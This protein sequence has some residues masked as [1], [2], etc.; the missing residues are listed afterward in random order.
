M[1]LY[2]ELNNADE[3]GFGL[4]YLRECQPVEQLIGVR[5]LDARIGGIRDTVLALGAADDPRATA[6]EAIRRTHRQ[7][8]SQSW[9]RA[10]AFGVL[11]AR[12][13]GN[14]WADDLQTEEGC[15]HGR[16]EHILS[17]ATYLAKQGHAAEDIM[18]A[19]ETIAR[20]H[21][22]HGR[23]AK[24]IIE[25]ARAL[26]LVMP[27]Q[28]LDEHWVT[29][30]GADSFE[31]N[32]LARM[33]EAWVDDL[34][35]QPL[36]HTAVVHWCEI[37]LHRDALALGIQLGTPTG[38]TPIRRMNGALRYQ[39]SVAQID[40]ML[41]GAPVPDLPVQSAKGISSLRPMQIPADRNTAKAA[42]VYNA[43]LARAHEHFPPR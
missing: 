25:T 42:R 10:Y 37:R 11:A 18:L 40:S 17:S 36:A 7:R 15:H 6:F 19:I 34:M 1:L 28:K 22:H 5:W 8:V 38:T 30:Y 2:P 41:G 43:M 14:R 3:P 39:H 31:A 4:D 21:A 27:G 20:M 33:M 29:S 13:A 32:D 12:E 23:E 16:S 26:D 35:A 24:M 9:E